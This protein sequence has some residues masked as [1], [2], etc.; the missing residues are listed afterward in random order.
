ME[1]GFF[2]KLRL[3]LVPLIRNDSIINV[4]SNYIGYSSASFLS[5]ELRTEKNVLAEWCAQRCIKECSIYKVF[6]T[7]R[8]FK[9]DRIKKNMYAIYAKWNKLHNYKKID[10]LPFILDWIM[11][12][13]FH[14]S[15]TL[16]CCETS[17]CP[18]HS[19]EVGEV[20]NVRMTKQSCKPLGLHLPVFFSKEIAVGFF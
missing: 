17:K 18:A 6:C 7:C 15:P 14:F 4:E 3:Q 10:T 19:S 11:R 20:R 5:R 2:I 16:F 12:I 8:G 1:Q 13:F 9:T